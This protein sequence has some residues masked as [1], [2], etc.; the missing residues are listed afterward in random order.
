VGTETS[1]FS[2]LVSLFAKEVTLSLWE[3]EATLGEAMQSFNRRMIASSNP[4]AFVFNCFGSADLKL[5]V[6]S[7]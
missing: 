2:D 3:K 1:V 5:A 6:S 4:L 7:P